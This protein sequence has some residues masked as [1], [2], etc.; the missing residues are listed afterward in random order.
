MK[1]SSVWPASHHSWGH[2]SSEVHLPKHNRFHKRRDERA[3]REFGSFEILW[4][5]YSTSTVTWTISKS[6]R[7]GLKCGS[8]HPSRNTIT[9]YGLWSNFVHLLLNCNKVLGIYSQIYNPTA[10]SLRKTWSFGR[11]TLHA[12]SKQY[13]DVTWSCKQYTVIC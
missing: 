8:R 4:I 6:W 13:Q 11:N 3:Q 9:Q 12:I 1:T 10:L 7:F 2:T 5:L